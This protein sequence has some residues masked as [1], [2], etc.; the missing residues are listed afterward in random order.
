[1][2]EI[3]P[4]LLATAGGILP[5]LAWLW[6]WLKEDK[7]HP[8]PRHLIALAFFVGMLTVALAIPAQKFAKLFITGTTTLFIAWSFIEEILKYSMARSTILWRR[9]VDEPLDMVIYMVVIALGFAAVENTLFLLSPLAGN[10]VFDTILT[11]NLRFIGAT[12]LHVLSSAVVGLV[13]AFTYY[14]KPLARNLYAL[15]GVIL[16][17]LLHSGFNFL[18][19]NS[20]DRYLLR[21]FALVWIGVVVV[22]A[23]LEII[24]RVRRCRIG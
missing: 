16:G 3:V 8:E 4:I 13:L 19:L 14:K 17:A 23:L 12:L 15:A 22:L 6:F 11:G 24:K 7:K 2:N 21:T 18:I 9:D 5:A 20:P 1:M 10:D